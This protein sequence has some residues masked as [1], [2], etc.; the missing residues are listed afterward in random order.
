MEQELSLLTL[1]VLTMIITISIIQLQFIYLTFKK[2]LSN[3]YS[4]PDCAM[5][6]QDLVPTLLE[7]MDSGKK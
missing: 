1:V 7:F 4:A 5:S 6:E 3:S 2:H